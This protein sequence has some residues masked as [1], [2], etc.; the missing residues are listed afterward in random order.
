MYRSVTCFDAIAIKGR[1]RAAFILQLLWLY[2]W[3]RLA[4]GPGDATSL[5]LIAKSA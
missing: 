2:A 1:R 4:K 3:R 5:A